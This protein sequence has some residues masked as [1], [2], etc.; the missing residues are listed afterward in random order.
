MSSLLHITSLTNDRVKALVRL[1]ERRERERT[2]L[3]LIEEP[4]VIGRALDAGQAVAEVWTCPELHDDATAALARRLAEAD[5]PRVEV[6]PPVMAKVAYRERPD[7][8]LLVAPRRSTALADLVLPADRPPLV[9]V[10]EE[11]E[12]PGNLGAALRIADG[13]G[14][15]AVIVCGRAGD[16]DNPNCLRASRGA[17]FSM[18][19]AL[20]PADAALAWL[21]ARNLAILAVTPEGASPWDQTDLRG[22]V[23]LVLGTEHDGLSAAMKQAADAAVAIPMHGT[24]DSL[25]VS[26]AAAVLLF[27]AIRQRRSGGPET[28]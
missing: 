20:A 7:G 22:P 1:R 3:F 21:R 2:G 26:A 11:V 25:N 19:T 6:T 9:L 14:A 10:L 17:F 18:P 27:E 16:F 28:P 15:D 5:V 24:G 8:L 13:A 12:K 23:A 4:L